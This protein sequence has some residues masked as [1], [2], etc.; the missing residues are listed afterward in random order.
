SMV[1]PSPMRAA[2]PAESSVDSAADTFDLRG[3]FG[4]STGDSVVYDA[5]GDVSI[6][7][8]RSGHVYF[9]IVDETDPRRIAL[10][11]TRQDALNGVAIDIDG[12]GALLD[13]HRILTDA[14][15][16][17]DAARETTRGGTDRGALTGAGGVLSE[18]NATELSA[19][20]AARIGDGATIEARR[21]DVNSVLGFDLDALAGGVAGGAVGIGVGIGVVT[22]QA[23]VLA[24]VD[25][26][27]TLIG[28]GASASDLNLRAEYDGDV[29]IV[30]FAGGGGFIS[31]GAAVAVVDDSTRVEALL[32]GD[33]VA[34]G[35]LAGDAAR[36]R[37]D[38]FDNVDVSADADVDYDLLTRFAS[39]GATLSL[40]AG[41]V[42]GEADVDVTAAVGQ[43]AHL[44]QD[45]SGAGIGDLAV[46]ATRVVDI[47]PK[48]ELDENGQQRKMVAGISAGFGAVNAGFGFVGV[49]GDVLA[50]IAADA[51]VDASG[52]IDVTADSDATLLVSLE[53]LSIGALAF[54]LILGDA[55]LAG[56][57]RATIGAR[58][59][60]AGRTV[61][62]RAQ[63]VMTSTITGTPTNIG[64]L[65][66]AGVGVTSSVG[67]LVS[68]SVGTDA[69]VETSGV[70]E[71]IRVTADSSV[72]AFAGASSVSIGLLSVGVNKPD[73]TVLHGVDA[74]IGA[75]A[76]LIA[77]FG[78]IRIAAD[79]DTNV[80]TATQGVGVAGIDI[81]IGETEASVS[82][83][84]QVI[85]LD[86][87]AIDAQG[88]L[89]AASR[90][91]SSVQAE[92]LT[93]GTAFGSAA[94]AR[95]S[96]TRFCSP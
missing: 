60:V 8:L 63:N 7:G 77:N 88:D 3:D 55:S 31:L 34:A 44:G 83:S 89:T 84:A 29:S 53:G 13:S 12:A 40:G 70:G 47:G 41:I 68:A 54:G 22:V 62:V 46:A 65:T 23:N 20:T 4:L 25:A 90:S 57:V 86:G 72:N 61:D 76:E 27:A 30:G 19:G 79:V 87:A 59:Q 35:P 58:A 50:T 32:G 71:A 11:A 10:A 95:P 33:A 28:D 48:G 16:F 36:L 43:G 38:G 69:K 21:I 74:T 52:D 49:T 2:V 5:G 82:Q 92:A 96:S 42:Y 94:K 91:T 39:V 51:V 93:D 73:A 81:S 9:A 6:A 15:E 1:A 67:A 64:L 24:K 26:G 75:G 80:V 18:T 14:A 66:G 78:D 45:A 17:S 56:T 85:I 37:A